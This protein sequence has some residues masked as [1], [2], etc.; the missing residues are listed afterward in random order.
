MSLPGFTAE[1]SLFKTEEHYRLIGAWAGG[2]AGQAVIP[3]FCTCFNLGVGYLCCGDIT[4]PPQIRGICNFFG[5]PILGCL[6]I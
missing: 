3:Q 1:A 2:N 5:S 4:A 6:V